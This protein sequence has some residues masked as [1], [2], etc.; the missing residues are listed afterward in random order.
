MNLK[1]NNIDFVDTYE[2]LHGKKS[3]FGKNELWNM[4][5]TAI[6]N[7]QVCTSILDYL[8]KK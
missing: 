3:G 7:D 8:N 4:H 1:K 5:H 2:Y 6:G